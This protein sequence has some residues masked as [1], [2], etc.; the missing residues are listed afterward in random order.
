MGAAPVPPSP[1]EMSMPFAPA[2][3]TP[4]AMVPTPPEETSLTVTR[5][6]SLAH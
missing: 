6:S 1:P 4:P 5:A 3:A 2:L